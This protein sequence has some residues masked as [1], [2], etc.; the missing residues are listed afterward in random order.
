MNLVL[1]YIMNK[2]VVISILL[3]SVS[4]TAVHKIDFSAINPNV[5]DIFNGVR[6]LMS[7]LFAKLNAP[8]AATCLNVTLNVEKIINDF[9]Y[10]IKQKF[11]AIKVLS[12]IGNILI[13]AIAVIDSC[14]DVYVGF[15]NIWKYMVYYWKDPIYWLGQI[16]LNFLYNLIDFF[17]DLGTIYT[18][19]DEGNYYDAGAVGGEFIYNVFFITILP[20]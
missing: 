7:S 20:S 15:D 11:E 3:I 14:Y 8:Q 4:A 16:G 9:N 18:D 10:L 12:L 6:G 1:I 5:S 2:L 19:M 17:A 13:E